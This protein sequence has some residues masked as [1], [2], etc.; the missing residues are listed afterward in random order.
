MRLIRGN[1]ILQSLILVFLAFNLLVRF[2]TIFRYPPYNGVIAG[3][4]GGVILACLFV[5][6]FPGHLRY[7]LFIFGF[8]FF[9]FGFGSIDIQSRIFELIVTLVA[10]TLFVSNNR[11]ERTRDQRSEVRGPGKSNWIENA[12]RKHSP[13]G[14]SAMLNRP[15][16][17][18]IV[19]YVV[20]SLFS[21]L[22][23]PVKQIFRDFCLFGFSDFFFYVFIN[24]PE[25]F[26]YPVS[27][28]IRLILFGV[29]AFQI[30]GSAGHHENYRYLFSGVFSGAVSC[31]LIGLLDY[32]GI[33]SLKWFRFGTTIT[34][35]ALHSTFGNRGWFGEFV[36]VSVPFVLI[37]FMSKIKGIWWR[38]FLYSSLVICEIA[39]LLAGGR[40][41]WVS[42]PAILFVCWLFFCFTKEGR[43]ESFH[44]RWKDLIKVAVS[45]PI[46][47]VISL[48]IV[49]YVFIPLS[50]QLKW[51]G[52][53][54]GVHQGGS[55][56]KAYLLN[57]A[58]ELIEPSGRVKAWTQGL[59]VGKE[60]P[61]LGL[62]FESFSWHAY[63][64]SGR[65]NS[66]YTLYKENKHPEVLQTPHNIFFSLFVSGGVVGLYMWLV[67]VLYAVV[68]LTADLIKQKRLLNVPV[69]I[70]IIS[71]HIFGI[72]QSMQYIPMIWSMIFLCLGYAMTIDERVL[73][74]RLRRITN[75]LTKTSVVLLCIGIFFYMSNFESRHLAQKYDLKMYALEQ[76]QNQFAG[77]YQPSQ[78]WRYGDYRWSGERGAI[79]VPENGGQEVEG[80]RPRLVALEFHCM[81]PGTEDDPVVV[82]VSHEGRVL[83]RI[84]FKGM[85]GETQ[86]AQQ[87]ANGKKLRGE[88]IVRRYDIPDVPGKEERLLMKVSRTWIPH[89]HL[90]NFDRRELGVGVRIL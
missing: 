4:V 78:R 21:L 26:Y 10:T 17:L 15:L 42:Y 34:P 11:A 85:G 7:L 60:S 65:P 79:Y 27:A 25:G 59:D 24:P 75:V 66:F 22:L 61:L 70:C 49:F 46:T 6:L 64:L 5:T 51:S 83:D 62:G 82:T 31:E 20:L 47:I 58:E 89:N 63:I 38:L 3:L 16:A 23:L 39:L 14:Q 81:T 57:I 68:I 50:D 72:F 43:L 28:I 40:S 77:F 12:Q 1:K 55:A 13:T 88:S 18:F 54:T 67:M 45:V 37:G 86:S 71:F 35:G 90:G 41:G 87:K 29:L 36:L 52:K 9:L 48:I 69:F 8:S 53:S 2:G 56:T 32:Y 76:D 19:C 84:V 44:F 80:G 74:D 73:S 33:I 30:S